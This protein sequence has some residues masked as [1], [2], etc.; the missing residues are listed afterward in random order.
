LH[1]F[2]SAWLLR[3]CREWAEH[4]TEMGICLFTLLI[5]GLVYGKLL[6]VTRHTLKTDVVNMLEGCKLTLDDL[7]IDYNRS[8][9]P[10]GM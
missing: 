2:G 10:M 8:F 4:F 6:G 3:K 7:K 5:S 1:L 9:M